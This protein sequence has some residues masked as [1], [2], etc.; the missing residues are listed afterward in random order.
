VPINPKVIEQVQVAL[1]TARGEFA[2][3]LI[4]PDV[5]NETKLIAAAI[6]QAGAQVALALAY[7]ET[8]SE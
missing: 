1:E 3:L 2:V 5:G 8:R 6:A 7:S 4:D